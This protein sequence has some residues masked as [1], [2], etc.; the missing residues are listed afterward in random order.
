MA[1]TFRADAARKTHSLVSG[2]LRD[3]LELLLAVAHEDGDHAEV[4]L[5]SLKIIK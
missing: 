5:E 1:R 2:L 4:V 3:L